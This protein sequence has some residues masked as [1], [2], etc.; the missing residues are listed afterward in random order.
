MTS[1]NQ[2]LECFNN[3]IKQLKII[4]PDEDIQIILNNINQFNNDKKIYNGLLFSS[5]INSEN[6]DLLVN[7]KIKLFSHKHS[8]TQEISESLFGNDFCLKNLLNNQSDE[9]KKVIW[10]NIQSIYSTIEKTKSEELQNK[11]RLEIIDKLIYKPDNDIKNK[12]QEMLDV[13]VNNDT[14]DMLDDIISSFEDIMN[15]SKS[16]NPLNGIMNISQKISVKYSDKINNGEIELDKLMESITKKVP[17]MDKMMN[18]MTD[19]NGNMKDMMGGMMSGLM[20]GNKKETK[21]KEK[22]IIDENFSTSNVEVGVIEEKAGNNFKIGSILKIADQFGVIPGGKKSDKT[23]N[24]TESQN[25]NLPGLSG[26]SGLSGGLSE[27]LS[28]LQNIEGMPNIGKMMELM[29]KMDKSS[30]I[31]DADL[32][33]QE[34]NTFLQN[35]LGIDITSFNNQLDE[36]TKKFSENTNDATNDDTNDTTNN[37]KLD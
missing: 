15:N 4:F 14:T 36:A 30:S 3:F 35:D 10:F 21:E 13:N 28:G 31:E 22:V 17:G 16:G 32:L 8:N 18:N 26:L 25:N 11:V 20:G 6:F 19:G 1:E 34:M 2:Y 29:Q 12:L 33:K 24:K 5:L 7:S 9:I 27:G 37:D 23:D